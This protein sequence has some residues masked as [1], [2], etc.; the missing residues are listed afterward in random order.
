MTALGFWAPGPCW[1]RATWTQ[2]SQ[3]PQMLPPKQRPRGRGLATGGDLNVCSAV[4]G[5]TFCEPWPSSLLIYH[6]MHTS[7]RLLKDMQKRKREKKR[8]RKRQRKRTRKRARKNETEREKER[9]RERERASER[10]GG[11]GIRTSSN[12]LCGISYAEGNTM[13]LQALAIPQ[14]QT[15]LD[16]GRS[17]ETVREKQPEYAFHASRVRWDRTPHQARPLAD[18]GRYML[19]ASSGR[20]LEMP[21]I[22]TRLQGPGVPDTDSKPKVDLPQCGSDVAPR[23]TSGLYMPLGAKQRVHKPWNFNPVKRLNLVEWTLSELGS[24]QPPPPPSPEPNWYLK[25][26]TSQ[27]FTLE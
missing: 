20:P 26:Q 16:W 3:R 24:A 12:H 7:T 25:P 6:E 27:K 1:Q 22:T 8:K 4:R 15:K 14:Q 21:L 18:K 23:C 17:Y 2:T 19:A 5:A 9:D 13:R 10:E 11:R